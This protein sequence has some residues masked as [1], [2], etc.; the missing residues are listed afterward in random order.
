ML[1]KLKFYEEMQKL[2]KQTQSFLGQRKT[3]AME[4]TAFFFKL[5]TFSEVKNQMW[6]TLYTTDTFFSFKEGCLKNKKLT[7]ILFPSNKTIKYLSESHTFYFFQ[8]LHAFNSKRIKDIS[9]GF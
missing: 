3:S 7:C 8:C 1:L 9:V 2:S 5:C 4:C 6:V